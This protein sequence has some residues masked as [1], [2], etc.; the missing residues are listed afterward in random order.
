MREFSIRV[1][2][3]K[4]ALGDASSGTAAKLLIREV[5]NPLLHSQIGSM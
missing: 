5:D 1:L 3:H 2:M 4:A